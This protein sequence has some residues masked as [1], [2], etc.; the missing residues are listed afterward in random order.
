MKLQNLLLPKVGI[1]TEE[2]MFFRRENGRER[3]VSFLKEEQ[4][5]ERGRN[6]PL[7]YFKRE[8]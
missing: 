1:C 6:Q 4:I 5:Y 8:V 2:Q 7:S 3:E